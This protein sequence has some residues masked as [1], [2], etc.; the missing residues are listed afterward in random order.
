[1]FFGHPSLTGGHEKAD[2]RGVPV[3]EELQF[4]AASG[5]GED[6]N[7][8]SS[9]AGT[10]GDNVAV[11]RGNAADCVKGGLDSRAGSVGNAQGSRGS[12]LVEL[13][14][15]GTRQGEVRGG[16]LG[17]VGEEEDDGALLASVAGGDVEVEDSAVAG[18]QVG[19]V[20]S[21]V[22]SARRVLVDGDDGVRSLVSAGEG[23]R[24]NVA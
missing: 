13:D 14:T 4:E 15:A 20:L 6:G 12:E 10:G 24:A 18:A 21:S 9:L 11:S 23:S 22:R 8:G 1:M 2:S 5:A 3:L 16:E 17:L 19:I 7:G